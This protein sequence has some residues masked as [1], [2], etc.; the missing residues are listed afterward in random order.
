MQYARK[1]IKA[2]SRNEDVKRYVGDCCDGR[3]VISLC[4]VSLQGKRWVCG[5]VQHVILPDAHVA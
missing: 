1:C 3:D 2:W 4:T 5:Q